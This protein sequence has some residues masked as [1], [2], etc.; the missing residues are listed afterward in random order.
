MVTALNFPSTMQAIFNGH[1]ITST[2]QVIKP[3]FTTSLA[4]SVAKAGVVTA[5]GTGQAELTEI[6][7]DCEKVAKN[8]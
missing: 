8:R 1:F 6:N 7:A 5:A 4:I 2:A 3:N